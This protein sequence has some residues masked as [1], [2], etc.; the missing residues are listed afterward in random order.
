M[1]AIER[2][3]YAKLLGETLP[4]V[5]QTEKQNERYIDVLERLAGRRDLKNPGTGW[6][7]R[8]FMTAVLRKVTTDL[9]AGA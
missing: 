9:A 3:A 6:F 8:L 2:S 7:R 1:T 4:T 5:I